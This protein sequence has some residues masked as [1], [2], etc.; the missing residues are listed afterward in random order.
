M[1]QTHTRAEESGRFEQL[2]ADECWLLLEQSAVARL[3]YVL[4][5][6]LELLPVTFRTYEGDGVRGLVFRT[7]ASTRLAGLVEPTDAVVE[8]DELDP[9]TATGWSVVARVRTG[10][11]PD[12]V[13]LPQPW[14]PGQRD[15]CIGLQV[16]SISGRI[17]SAPQQS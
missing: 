16:T 3:A 2:P 5:G 17:V 11:A 14:A 12:G 15:V 4:A 13:E 1:S 10:P 7:A 8:L 9:D 6:R